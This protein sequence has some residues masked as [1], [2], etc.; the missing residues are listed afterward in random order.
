M[1][2]FVLNFL[3]GMFGSLG[4]F[5]VTVFLSKENFSAPFFVVFI[6]A[7]CGVLSLFFGYV[8]TWIILFLYSAA[9]G[10]EYCND[11]KQ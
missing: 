4:M 5:L 10:I 6:G 7:V 8:S 2:L 1:Q 9:C 3:L 11:K